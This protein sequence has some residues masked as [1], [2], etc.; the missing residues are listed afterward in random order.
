MAIEDNHTENR[1]HSQLAQAP[2]TPAKKESGASRKS[3]AAKSRSAASA[4]RSSASSG[5]TSSGASSESSASVAAGPQTAGPILDWLYGVTPHHT[6]M[7]SLP[8]ESHPFCPLLQLSSVHVSSIATIGLGSAGY[9]RPSG[10][11]LLELLFW[12]TSWT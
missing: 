12:A 5:S 6:E 11:L 7:P 2:T 10:T 4:P 1:Q 8:G 3:K 9:H